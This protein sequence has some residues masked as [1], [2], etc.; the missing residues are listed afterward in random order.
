MRRSWLLAAMVLVTV[1]VLMGLNSGPVTSTQALRAAR[2]TPSTIEAP[3]EPFC[4]AVRES[5]LDDPRGYPNAEAHAAALTA[6][7][8][9]ATPTVRL[10]LGVL[11][12][13]V[14]SGGAAEQDPA[15]WPAP[16]RAVVA[17]IEDFVAANC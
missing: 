3:A 16:V 4:R 14:A 9:V 6:L 12:Q 1:V 17:E 2:T 8:S 10:H 13:F 11:R 7:E 5:S 15:R